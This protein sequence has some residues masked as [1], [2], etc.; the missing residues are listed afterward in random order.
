MFALKRKTEAEIHAS[1]EEI[2]MTCAEYNEKFMHGSKTLWHCDKCKILFEPNE[3]IIAL[4]LGKEN[5]PH[6]AQTI[7]FSMKH[8]FK[9]IVGQKTCMNRLTCGE[10]DWW[11]KNYF[12]TKIP[13]VEPGNKF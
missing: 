1:A 9:V 12:V 4:V 7:T 10:R 6:C 8:W 2:R 5:S 3:E 13:S 11:E